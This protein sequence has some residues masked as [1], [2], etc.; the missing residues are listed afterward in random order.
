MSEFK[1]FSPEVE[2]TGE[3]LMAFLAGFP[4]EFRSSGF[5]ILEKH[6][7][8]DPQTNEYYTLQN[9]LDAMKEISDSF[10]T[11]M[12]SRI[13]EQIALHAVLPPGI[14]DL[15]K[16]LESID[17]AYHMNHR[18]GEIGSYAYKPLGTEGGLGRAAMTCLNPYP[19]AFDRG[20]I[21]G[22]AKRFKS[23][24]SYDVVVRHDDSQPCR[25]KG[26]ESCTYVITWL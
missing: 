14:D 7:L 10:S 21:E 12:L 23:S 22:F 13:G 3:V 8:A 26:D 17:V 19:C 4:E 5:R 1:S 2:V 11:Q 9:L 15:E 20:V 6:G 24:G 25:R 18:G 16:C